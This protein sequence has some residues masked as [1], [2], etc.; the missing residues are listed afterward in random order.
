MFRRQHARRSPVAAEVIAQFAEPDLLPDESGYLLIE[1]ARARCVA[2]SG[3]AEGADERDRWRRVHRELGMAGYLISA[4]LPASKRRSLSAEARQRSTDFCR[5]SADAEY[6]VLRLI[7]AAS[8]AAGKGLLVPALAE[9]MQ[10]AAEN[11]GF[12]RQIMV[13]ALTDAGDPSTSATR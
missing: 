2:L 11:L 4:E 6:A 3:Q 9:H 13:V 1:E 10:A 7:T 5:R 8:S 12:A